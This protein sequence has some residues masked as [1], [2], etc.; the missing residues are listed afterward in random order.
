MIGAADYSTVAVIAF[1]GATATIVY[2]LI[3]MAIP[4]IGRSV[5]GDEV[6]RGL[7][8]INERLRDHDREHDRLWDKIGEVE[9]EMRGRP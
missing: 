7:V 9:R 5:M 2:K 4:R 1:M 8:P 6:Q 3:G